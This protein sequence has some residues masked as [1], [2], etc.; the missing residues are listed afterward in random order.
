LCDIDKGYAIWN[1]DD[2]VSLFWKDAPDNN[3]D[4]NQQVAIAT[5][6]SREIIQKDEEHL[7]RVFLLEQQSIRDAMSTVKHHDAQSS[8]STHQS[9]HQSQQQSPV[10]DHKKKKK[11]KWNKRPDFTKMKRKARKSTPTQSVQLLPPPPP[12]SQNIIQPNQPS[13]T[14]QLRRTHS[15]PATPSPIKV[16]LDQLL[17]NSSTNDHKQ[18]THPRSA[19][20]PQSAQ[21]LLSRHFPPLQKRVVHEISFPNLHTAE[22]FRVF[23][24]DDAPYSMKD[25]QL[26]RGDVDV[27]YGNWVEPTID[28]GCD[29]NQEG[30]GMMCASFKGCEGTVG[31]LPVVSSC[32][33][34]R[35]LNFNTLTKR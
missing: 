6:G 31:V 26:K 35:V 18:Y 27:V 1:S 12:P 30:D 5:V 9:Q 21:T 22:F 16:T 7:R 25:F 17:L 10:M 19:T 8:E 28:S 34:E 33:R 20:Q 2:F 15:A 4:D 32:V 14:N 3:D 24:A 23:F 13:P 29:S 11:D